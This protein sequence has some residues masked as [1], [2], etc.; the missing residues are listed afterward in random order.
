MYYVAN[1]RNPG[2]ALLHRANTEGVPP[3]PPVRRQW[4]FGNKASLVVSFC[5]EHLHPA[6]LPMH[7]EHGPITLLFQIALHENRTNKRVAQGESCHHNLIVRIE[8]R[9]HGFNV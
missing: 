7:A 3:V 5:H 2:V 1:D 6:L 8:K 9:S 4:N